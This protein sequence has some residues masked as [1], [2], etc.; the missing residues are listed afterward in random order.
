[1][2]M[3]HL[4]DYYWLKN[5]YRPPEH[6]PNEYRPDWGRYRDYWAGEETFS[7]NVV[8][9]LPMHLSCKEYTIEEIFD[10]T[11]WMKE[12]I[13]NVWEGPIGYLG[14]WK[15]RFTAE[16]DMVAVKLYV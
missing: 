5:Q 12:N 1:M 8:C 10:L 6:N 11:Q 3:T 16:E 4:G 7:S 15:F 14:F 13:E 9:W 2:T